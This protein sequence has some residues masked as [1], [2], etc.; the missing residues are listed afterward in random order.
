M[1]QDDTAPHGAAS[2]DARSP[3]TPAPTGRKPTPSRGGSLAFALLLSLVAMGGAGYIGWRQWQ[4]ERTASQDSQT[5]A[6]LR[7]RL[8]SMQQTI[9]SLDDDRT[10]LRQRL[11][12]A[13]QVNRGLRE[14]QFGQAER[15][16]NLE[17]AVA[18]LS[19]KSLS[20]HDAMLLDEAESLLRWGKERFEL[21]HDAQGAAT[22]YTAADQ[23]L[24]SVNDG[25]FSGLRQSVNA[26]HEALIKSAPASREAAM[27][28]LTALRGEVMTL[29]LK[30]LDSQTQVDAGA[31]ARLRGALSS[32]ITIRRDNGAPLAV[33]DARFARELA[34]LDLAQAQLALMAYDRDAYQAA[35]QRAS[36]TLSAQFDAQAPAVQQAARET[37]ALAAQMPS[38]ANVQLGAALTELRNLRSV[39]ALK[40][41]EAAAPAHASSGAHP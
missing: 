40:P 34:S 11:G 29:P 6:S 17:D 1:S 7:Q 5:I 30:P 13:D 19:E 25:A 16:R 22:A 41:G 4:Q 39:H 33:A 15:V 32:V 2:S 10:A 28:H 37:S 36:A 20:G 14:E 35:L 9:T 23:A 27:T 21:F 18:K 24:A 12:D 38:M 3:T 31:W 8:D 26:E